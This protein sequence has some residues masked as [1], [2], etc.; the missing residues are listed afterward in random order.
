MKHTIVT[1]AACICAIIFSQVSSAQDNTPKQTKE[2]ETILS[3]VD[4]ISVDYISRYH[5]SFFHN[6]S[7]SASYGANLLFAEEDASMA[8]GKRFSPVWQASIIKEIIPSVAVRGSFGMG[9][10]AGW[11]SGVGGMYKWEADW[12]PEDPVKAYYEG[13][14][15]DCSA[16]YRSV[17]DYMHADVDALFNIRNIVNNHEQG[18]QKLDVYAL[19][20]VEYLQ[21]L[22]TRGYYPTRKVGYRFGGILSFNVSPRISINAELTGLVTDAT[23]DNE[24]GKGM[25]LNAYASA[26]AGI[27]VSLGRIGYNVERL[28]T[29]DQYVKMQEIITT[30][31]EEYNEEFAVTEIVNKDATTS[32]TGTL[33]APSI[34]FDEGA[35]T[36]S[37]ELQMVNLYR[38]ARYMEQNPRLKV[39]VIGNIQACDNRL[40][41][42]R[43]ELVRSVLIKRYGIA[44]DRLRISL[45]DV[46]REYHVTGQE[47]TVN[48]GA[49]L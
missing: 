35:E 26:S 44:P 46:N 1:A 36:Y 21:V 14:G 6:W 45:Q 48:F 24:I 22:R 41:R 12:L 28:V 18:T 40:A 10:L 33:F 17:M 11:N 2:V 8:F 43:A 49:L 42:K 9:R 27:S 3:K 30:V 47:Q 34:V 16:G 4:T 25:G 19:M 29:P 5:S 23:F 39:V 37:E 13:L 20:G 38:I 15:Q 32:T 31:S 7:I